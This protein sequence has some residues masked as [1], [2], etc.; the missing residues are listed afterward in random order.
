MYKS[1]QIWDE[2]LEDDNLEDGALVL[3][4]L[5][6]DLFDDDDRGEMSPPSIAMVALT[7]A[8]VVRDSCLVPHLST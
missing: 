8:Q 7:R 6:N 2:N 3:Q 4:Q 5:E 1:Y